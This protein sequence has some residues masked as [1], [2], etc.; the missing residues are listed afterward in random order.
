[1]EVEFAGMVH[2]PPQR[3]SDV[4]AL[5]ETFAV[6]GLPTK[7][8]GPV[9]RFAANIKGHVERARCCCGDR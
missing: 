4:P 3:L 6:D 9:Q 2:D 7:F 5:V 1:M 8:D